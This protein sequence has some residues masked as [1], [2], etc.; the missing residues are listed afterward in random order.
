VHGCAHFVYFISPGTVTAFVRTAF[1]KLQHVIGERSWMILKQFRVLALLILALGGVSCSTIEQQVG[2]A[3]DPRS[4]Q[5]GRTEVAEL[6]PFGNPSNATRDISN[7]NNFLVFKRS[8]A[9]SYNNDRGTVNWVAWRTAISDLGNSLQ[10]PQFEPDPDLPL[11]FK[12]I[13]PIDYSGSGYDRGHM[14]PS[15]DRFGDPTL[16]SET[17]LMTNVVPQSADL[18]QYVWEKLERYARGIVRRGSDVYTIAG[19]YGNKERIKGKLVVPTNCWKVMIVLPPGGSALNIDE[20]S[21]VIAVDI[22]NDNGIKNTYWQKFRV[23]VREIEQKTGF[24][25]FSDLPQE[26]QDKLEGSVDNY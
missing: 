11:T 25:L 4:K 18:N 13:M 19:V 23:P 21:R 8:F 24:N 20:N 3:I 2:K 22:P 9:F 10:R 26:L 12:R 6:L 1:V 15:A 14:V 16:N 17:F 7:R 5:P